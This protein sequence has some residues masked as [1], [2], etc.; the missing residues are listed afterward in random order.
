MTDVAEQS[1]CGFAERCTAAMFT[2]LLDRTG[3]DDN[4]W[5]RAT[6]GFVGR[7]EGALTVE[8]PTSLAGELLSSCLGVDASEDAGP[9]IEDAAGEF[10]NMVV[11]AWL[12]RAY[13]D[14]KF[15]LRPPRLERLTATGRNRWAAEPAPTLFMSVN[16]RPVRLLLTC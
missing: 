2:E 6:L 14:E 13:P 12:T 8:M 5:L 9:G 10:A 16:D 11:G 1:F 7:L 3:E 4:V 15:D